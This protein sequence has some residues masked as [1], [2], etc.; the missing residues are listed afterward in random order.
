[1]TFD[2]ACCL[3]E[4]ALT[5]NTRRQALIDLS[6]SK[7]KPLLRLRE[8][9]R[10]GVLRAGPEQLHFDRIVK[11]FERRTA[12]EGFH[13]LHDWDGKADRL[14]DDIIP[15][16]VLNYV[17]REINVESFERSVLAILLDYYFVYVLALLS[18]SVW[19]EGNA[20]LNL[21]RL[22][23]ILR[24]LQGP[25]GSGQKF[26]ENAETLILIATSHFEPDTGAYE[27]LLRKVRALSPPHQV[28]IALVHAAILSGH[29]RHGFQGLY[30]KDI[31]AMRDDNV[32]DYLWLCFALSTL[33]QAYARMHDENIV[34]IERQKIV[35]GLLNG[36]SPD[37]RAFLGKP[38]ASL[39][40]YEMDLAGFRLM[41]H[42]YRED[43][44][45]EFESHRPSED[46]SPMSFTFNFPHNLLKAV[47]IDALGRGKPWNLT[48]NDLL[49]GIPRE[50]RGQP[51]AM[52]ARTLVGYARSSPEMVGGRLVPAID[53]DS[54]AGLQNYAKTTGIIKK[55]VI[56]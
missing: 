21:D 47:V 18:L 54:Q 55:Q 53:Y 37:P 44:F 11:P 27:R 29:L 30:R 4:A 25:N 12:E 48:L 34:G 26:A 10:S 1:V 40:A 52:L 39:A 23:E 46:Y 22:S 35:E 33:M 9:M 14:N 43:L 24:R 42:K 32:P 28:Q 38:P 31:A 3:L 56:E 19:A 16:D 51:K 7:N 49:T 45:E 15:V 13:V 6:K 5:A 36:L 41:F 17:L 20:D 8:S 2:G 50:G